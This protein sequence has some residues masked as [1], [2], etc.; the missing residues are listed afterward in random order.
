MP[1]S[2]H[3][4]QEFSMPEI[5]LR[6]LSDDFLGYCFANLSPRDRVKAFAGSP[7]TVWLFGAGASHHYNLNPRSVP[8]PLANGFF[9]AFHSLPTSA[10]LHAHIGPLTSY[11][12]Q[13]RGIPLERASEWKENIEA[14]M[15]SVEFRLD[16]LRAKR[17]AKKKLSKTE[18][19]E[20]YSLAMVF[21][22]MN[23][24]FAS[25]V[26]EAQNGPSES[27]YRYL[28]EFCGPDDGFVTFNWDTLLDRALA[29]SGGWSPN[30]GY[31]IVFRAALDSTW[32][33]SVEGAPQ[34]Q[35]NW[36]LLKLHGSTNWIVPY[37]HINFNTFKY[38]SLVPKSS[39]IFLYWQSLLP[40]D[41]YQG[42]W[43]GGYAPTCYCF[44]PPNLPSQFFA[45]GE[46]SAP[47]GK[48]IVSA[49]HTGIFAPFKEPYL[50][51]VPAS[52]LLITPVRQKKYDMYRGAVD[53]LWKQAGQM[54]D[55]ADR[56]VIIG[57][58]FPPTD[59]RAFK[60][61]A[62]ALKKRPSKVSVDIV[63]PDA[64][65]VFDRIE[66]A[67]LSKARRVS[68]YEMK[69]EDFL[70][71]LSKSA[72]NRIRAAALRHKEIREWIQRL[73]IMNKIA[74]AHRQDAPMP[75]KVGTLGRFFA[76]EYSR[77]T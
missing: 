3:A 74:A 33:D 61:L 10:G 9:E 41:T 75:N 63:A 47:P 7:R 44:Y 66:D 58:S 24:I 31:G 21:T 16:R 34:F 49:R 5:D 69:F 13:Y 1:D 65:S 42:R 18:M 37:T 51:G 39:S 15:T 50:P 67:C 56:I 8:V 64:E 27:A 6:A 14:F 62:S 26:N 70:I 59:T 76:K 48:V 43:R 55:R 40:Y 72:P 19:D 57:Y 45:G 30:E 38:V 53:A 46:L 54:L 28:L 71:V 77:Y 20:F 32:K 4:S 35:T 73:Y 23:F 22:N 60:L 12:A 2:P 52:P 17:M 68:V 29:D 36:K 11:I 25:V